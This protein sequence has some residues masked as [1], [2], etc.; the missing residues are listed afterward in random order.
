M[1]P[2]IVPAV[3]DGLQVM[4]FPHRETRP[5]NI[6]LSANIAFSQRL[7]SLHLDRDSWNRTNTKD[8]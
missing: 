4:P 5:G 6:S 1:H 3:W 7:G 8:T 2:V